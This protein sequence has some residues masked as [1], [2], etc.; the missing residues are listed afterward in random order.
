MLLTCPSCFRLNTTLYRDDSVTIVLLVATMNPPWKGC[1]FLQLDLAN[2]WKAF[3]VAPCLIETGL[4]LHLGF[5][6]S[7]FG[8]QI[9]FKYYKGM[10]KKRM[11]PHR[12]DTELPATGAYG[13]LEESQSFNT[14]STMWP[15]QYAS[16]YPQNIPVKNGDTD[17][18]FIIWW[19]HFCLNCP[20]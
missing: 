4:H 13:S 2:H 3:N 11:Q 19:Q 16:H 18:I 14:S 10:E 8:Q 15:T 12:G 9:N 17:V 5:L 20:L 1:L 6:W 7:L